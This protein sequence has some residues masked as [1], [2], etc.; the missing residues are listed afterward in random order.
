MQ[1]IIQK[2]NKMMR[3]VGLAGKIM[4]L[5]GQAAYHRERGCENQAL[6]CEIRADGLK[7]QAERLQGEINA[8]NYD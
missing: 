3:V 5:N 2:R 1:N 6:E 7:E 8:E 4:A